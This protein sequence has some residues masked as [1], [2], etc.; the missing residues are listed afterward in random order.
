M[1]SRTWATGLAC[2]ALGFVLS[3]LSPA[4]LTGQVRT[5]EAAPVRWEYKVIAPM[6][7]TEPAA[8]EE[9]LNNHGK[10]SWELSW[11]GSGAFVFKRAVH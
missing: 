11:A 3:N 8:I 6:A 4:Q 10:N 2:V 7:T 9:H 5:K 1:K